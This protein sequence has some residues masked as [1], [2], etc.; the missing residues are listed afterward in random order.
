MEPQ[1]DI[2]EP[3]NELVWAYLAAHP[4]NGMLMFAG[5]AIPRPGTK[6]PHFVIARTYSVTV[7][8]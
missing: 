5:R 6:A 4:S 2:D 8:P 3:R 7:T 1:G